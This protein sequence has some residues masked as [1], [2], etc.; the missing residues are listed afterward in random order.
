LLSRAG[1][2]EGV[3]LDSDGARRLLT[4]LDTYAQTSGHFSEEQE[5]ELAAFRLACAP[6]LEEAQP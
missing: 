4:W 3:K 2:H 5:A 1:G 6:L